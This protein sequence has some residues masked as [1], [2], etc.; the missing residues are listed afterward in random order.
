MPSGCLRDPRLT[1][2][3]AAQVGEG[4]RHLKYNRRNVVEDSH[5]ILW[6]ST[7]GHLRSR[8][9]VAVLRFLTSLYLLCVHGHRPRPR[10]FAVL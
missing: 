10:S 7:P 6:Y 3:F 1:E 9:A 8:E 5:R 4:P 2:C